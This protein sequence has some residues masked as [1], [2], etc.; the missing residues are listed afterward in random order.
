MPLPW[1]RRVLTP[2]SAVALLTS[3]IGG[4]TSIELRRLRQSLRREELLGGGG[5]TSDALLVEALLEP[6]A[7]ATLGIEG[8]SARR[9]A[10]M[11]QAG[12]EAA[13]A[14]GGQRRD[15]ALGA[16]ALHRAGRRAGPKPPWPA[17]PPEP[18]P[19]ATSMP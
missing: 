18:G 2:E 16:L 12:R 9:M 8:H 14:P 3:R 1:T 4:A 6:G 5:R 17:D 15:G 10:R 11:I 7:L 13:E 19:T